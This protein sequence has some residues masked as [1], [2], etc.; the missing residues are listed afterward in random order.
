[1]TKGERDGEN[2]HALILFLSE[3]SSSLRCDVG[4]MCL[5]PESAQEN[6]GFKFLWKVRPLKLLEDGAIAFCNKLE[7]HV[8]HWMIDRRAMRW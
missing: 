8:G 5:D 7:N 6:A 2:C 1:M 3:R 4:I